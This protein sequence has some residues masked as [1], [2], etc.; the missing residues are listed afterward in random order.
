MI[1]RPGLSGLCLMVLA[2]TLGC[3]KA[4]VDPCG[5]F[6]V[7][8]AQLFDSTISASKAFPPKGDEKNDLCLYY[9]ANGEPRLML[10]VWSAH[11][12]DPV[13]AVQSGMR[14]SDSRIVEITG[15]GEKAAAGFRAG[16]L[17]LF[18]AGNKKG[19]IGARVRDPMTQDDPKFDEVKA[20][21]AR[22]LGRLK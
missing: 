18:A 5:L 15:V 1:A 8:E 13:E 2:A 19:T 6:S 4:K 21:V 22:V 14:E 20:L 3:S 10:F 7:S 17:R 11:K 9:N 16:E 12:I